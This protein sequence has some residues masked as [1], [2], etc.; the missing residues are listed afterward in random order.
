MK[1]YKIIHRT[2]Y[3]FATPVT[4]NPHALMLRPR[5]SHELRIE[6][7][8]LR[9]EPVAVLRW[10]RDVEDNS[11]AIAEFSEQSDR[12][13]IYSEVD[14]QHFN[15]AP[16]DF[17]LDEYAVNYPFSYSEENHLFLRPYLMLPKG[18]V[19]KRFNSWIRS[20]TPGSEKLQTFEFLQRLMEKINTSFEY[21]I[22][23]EEGIQT[24]DQT[25]E[26]GTGSCRDFANLFIL[27]A[28][29]CG[30]AARFVSGY[31]NTI[32]PSE[33]PGA[34]HAWAEVYLPGAGW[35]GFDPTSGCVVGADHIPVA[36][37]HNPAGVPP[38]SGSY[39]G[40]PGAQLQV[41]VWVKSLDEVMEAGGATAI[42]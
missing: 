16:L 20:V 2:V 27:T 26:F 41:G 25:L 12:L 22:R 36:V 33:I 15:E 21:R 7:S 19:C 24:P 8:I 18:T 10:V 30:L 29:R 5:D 11:I 38:V 31:L 6:A 39:I 32:G 13:E 9:I 34:T 28:R 23:E 35:K 42:A 1:R 17:I 14:I 37:S 40:P 4:L 3:T